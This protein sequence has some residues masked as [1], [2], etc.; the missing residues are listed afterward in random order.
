[1]GQSFIVNGRR[2]NFVR[3]APLALI[4][5]GR[6]R[7]MTREPRNFALPGAQCHGTCGPVLREGGDAQGVAAVLGPSEGD[8][9]AE[10][11]QLE[12]VVTILLQEGGSL[13][14]RVSA[15]LDPWPPEGGNFRKRV[16]RSFASYSFAMSRSVSREYSVTGRWTARR[17]AALT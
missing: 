6:G 15:I 3:L 12:K 14:E 5:K 4:P 11:Q 8:M 9:F 17:G 16:A 10:T 13:R 2:V 1:M 7:G